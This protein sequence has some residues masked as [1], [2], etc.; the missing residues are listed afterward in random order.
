MTNL[1]IPG[2][3][4]QP[5]TA[6]LDV[7]PA[8]ALS[9]TCPLCQ[10]IHPSLT[11]DALEVGGSWCCARCGQHWSAARLKTVSGYLAWVARHG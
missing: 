5:V 9:G 6:T 10:T 11:G 7:E 3:S 1:L 8:D 2:P 4:R